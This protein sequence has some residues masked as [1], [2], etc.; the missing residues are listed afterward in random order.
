MK[1]KLKFVAAAATVLLLLPCVL[2]VLLSGRR[3]V[4]ISGDGDL[5]G[6]VAAC[7]YLAAPFSR[8]EEMLKAQAVLMRSQLYQEEAQGKLEG[9]QLQQIMIQIQKLQGTSEFDQN[10]RLCREAAEATRNQVLAWQ[11]QRCSGA[12]HY[13][14]A[15]TTRDG[16]QVLQQQEYGYLQSVE[17]QWDIQCPEYLSGKTFA[18]EEL[19]QALSEEL[20]GVTLTEEDLDS[21]N[22]EK[23]DTAGYV[24][25]VRVKDQLL[26]GETF[27]QVLDLSS[28]CFTIQVL[29]G[30]IRFICKGVGHGLGMSQYGAMEMAA[31]GALYDEILKTYFPEAEIQTETGV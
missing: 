13:L 25:E 16:I 29:E 18:P 24:L 15:G 17:S 23:Q 31:Q 2:T 30:Q 10:Y 8:E 12:F 4:T 9:E 14:S 1:E 28:S 21:I 26:P 20:P 19:V 3:A 11:G 6:Y 22:V 27:A 5:E 7:T